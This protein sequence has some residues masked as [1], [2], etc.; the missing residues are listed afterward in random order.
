MVCMMT[1]GGCGLRGTSGKNKTFKLYIN[2][3]II[4]NW[5]VYLNNF[6]GKDLVY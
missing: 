1:S 5:P 3:Q 4:F 6:D 2:G